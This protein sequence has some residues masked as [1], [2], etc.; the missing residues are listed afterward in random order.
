[1]GAAKGPGDAPCGVI[2]GDFRPRPTDSVGD[3]L[4]GMYMKVLRTLVVVGLVAAV[5]QAGGGVRAA[6]QISLGQFRPD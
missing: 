5:L 1:M 2:C 6:E 4:G 3:F